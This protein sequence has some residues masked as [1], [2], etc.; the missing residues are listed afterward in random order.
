MSSILSRKPVEVL[1]NLEQLYVGVDAGI[2]EAESGSRLLAFEVA[3]SPY[4][5]DMTKIDSIADPVSM[6]ALPKT[7]PWLRGLV[8]IRG[9]NISVVDLAVFMEAGEP[10]PSGSGQLL[11][12]A[13][14]ELQASLLVDSVQGLRNADSGSF[15]VREGVPADLETEIASYASQVYKEDSMEWAF[16]DIDSI[17]G[18]VRFRE[19]Q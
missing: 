6:I 13:D 12:L 1:L 8:N 11:V 17:A 9:K 19:V 15:S 7:K 3:G 16:L 10:V 14:A 18:S 2:E 5:C 4:V